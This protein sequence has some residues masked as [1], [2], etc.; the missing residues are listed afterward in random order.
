MIRT[1]RISGRYAH[2]AGCRL[3]SIV[4]ASRRTRSECVRHRRS[5]SP[6]EML[7]TCRKRR[8]K[9]LADVQLGFDGGT[10]LSFKLTATVTGNLDKRLAV[11]LETF[12]NSLE[13]KLEIQAAALSAL[14]EFSK[15]KGQLFDR[16][17]RHNV[18]DF[19]FMTEKLVRSLGIT[20]LVEVV[21]KKEAFHASCA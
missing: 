9:S 5:K 19:I 18:L 12:C 20:R 3:R 13:S 6:F 2:E 17:I 7:A 21:R 4:S 10:V 8:K 16:K 11:E 14:L 1:R 15:L